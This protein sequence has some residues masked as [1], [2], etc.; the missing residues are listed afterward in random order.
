MGYGGETIR[1]QTVAERLV[2][3][4]RTAQAAY[5]KL[6]MEKRQ[7]VIEALRAG[8]R[9]LLET[10]SKEELQ[11]TGMGRT[12][13]K[14]RKLLAAVEKT[15]GTED[16]R[17][18][19]CMGNEEM[20]LHEYAAYGVV[21]AVQPATNPCATVISN[22]ISMLAA[23]NAVIHIPN[24]RAVSCSV[25][26]V[27]EIEAIVQRAIGIEH[28]VSVLPESSMQ[29]ADELMYHPDVDLVTITGG[30]MID[31]GLQ[32]P[33]RVIGA[34]PANPVAIV[35]ETADLAQAAV[36]LADSISFD[37]NI[38]CTGEKNIV[39]MDAVTDRLWELLEQNGA[40]CIR[41]TEEM[42]QLT[43][44]VVT[45]DL[46]MNRALEGRDAD[47]ILQAAGLQD[48]KSYR[49]IVVDTVKTHP[50]ATLEL[51]MPVVPLIRVD[52]F[53]K[54]LETAVFLE[55]GLHHTAVIHSQ[56]IKRLR[57]AAQ[58]LQT[59]VFVKNGSAMMGAGLAGE[60]RASF[61]IANITGEGVTTAKTFARRRSCTMAGGFLLR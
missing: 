51:L 26:A 1:N 16:L 6:G 46:S 52:T 20:T 55:Q 8:L 42:L 28:L 36:D 22:T 60:G 38:L 44:V 45:A 14:R 37:N 31:R 33:K 58:T 18:E 41:K 24:P 4:A 30:K 50:L 43:K 5:A 61:T 10:F 29:L 59:A 15:P 32:A 40:R 9:P 2:S 27:R 7:A 11:E 54:A 47:E 34:G 13:D 35:D 17:S 19:V 12:E 57:Q 56:N 39:V 21:C 23:G 53:E 25:H 49:F 3:E 48:G